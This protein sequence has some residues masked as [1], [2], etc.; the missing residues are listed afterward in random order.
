MG[1][2]SKAVPAVSAPQLPSLVFAVL[3]GLFFYVAIIKLGNAVILDSVVSPP[4]GLGEILS[5]SWPAKWGFYLAIPVIV[6]GMWATPW[7]QIKFHALF[8]LPVL[9]LGWEFIAA[10]QSISPPLTRQTMAHFTVCVA[11]F[12]AAYFGL[13]GGPTWPIWTGIGLALFWVIRAGLQQHFGGLAST[14]AYLNSPEGMAALSEQTLKNPD[15]IKRLNSNRIFSTFMEANTF[16]GGLILMLPLTL[17]YMWQLTPKVR[18]SVR[19]VF[20][21]IFGG[22]GLA[23]LYWSGSKAGWLVAL[24]VG[25]LALW[26]SKLSLKWRR[27]LIFAVLVVGIAGFAIKYAAF[28]HKERNSVSA[29]FAYWRAALIIV[30]NHPWIGTGPG[31]FEIS[32]GKLRR[33]D[34]EPTKLCHDDYLQQGCDSGIPGF[35]LYTGAIIVIMAKL[36]RYSIPKNLNNWIPFAIYLG[37]LGVFLHSFVD[38]HLYI[39][40]LAWTQFFLLGWLAQRAS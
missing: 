19:I 3:A 15:F 38:F 22:A 18:K 29:R 4:V 27:T 11:L 6:I 17:V 39:P 1:T 37:V 10:T 21:V 28:F 16:A 33:P 24:T 30:K 9:W 20:I 5:E 31:T 13:Q 14:R 8:L 35:L 7:K 25:L 34:D 2:K 23:C 32:Y 40:A 12:Y 36:Y 26:H